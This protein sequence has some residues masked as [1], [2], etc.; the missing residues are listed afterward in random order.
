MRYL[1]RGTAQDLPRILALP[2]LAFCTIVDIRY[3]VIDSYFDESGA[4]VPSYPRIEIDCE[5]N[6]EGQV[7]LPT[8]S[9]RL[10]AAETLINLILDDEGI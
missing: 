2:E 1:Y 10:Q 3:S 6:P 5:P 7:I 9:D 4:I 8:A